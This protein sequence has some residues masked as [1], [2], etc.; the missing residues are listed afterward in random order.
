VL[1]AEERDAWLVE[2]QRRDAA[3]AV[4]DEQHGGALSPSHG[5]REALWYM[6]HALDDEQWGM[7]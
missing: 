1:L 4:P 2:P 6:P 3:G 7:D 5:V